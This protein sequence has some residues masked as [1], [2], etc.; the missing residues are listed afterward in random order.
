M[1]IRHLPITIILWAMALQ[2]Q[3]QIPGDS[4]ARELIVAVE[5][6]E[7]KAIKGLL[8][9]GADVNLSVPSRS[10][11]YLFFIGRQVYLDGI[12]KRISAEPVYVSAIHANASRANARTLP[13]LLK[14]GANIDAGDS[15]GKTPLMYA[16]R[17]PGGESYALQLLQQGA[18]YTT[19]DSAGNSAM[20]Y[21]ALGGNLEGIYL[22]KSGG[23][24]INSRNQDGMT[25][26]HVAV[27]RS[28]VLVFDEMLKLGA[29][30]YVRDNA[31][32]NVLHYAA[33]YGSRDLVKR[34]YEMAP[35]LFE[36]DDT[37]ANPLDIAHLADNDEVAIY[38]RRKGRNFGGYRYDELLSAVRAGNDSLLRA[39]LLD[40]ANPNRP[41]KN[42]PIH[43][44]AAAGDL[45]CLDALLD[46]H[47]RLDL[48]D[49]A[50]RSPLRVAIES[51]QPEAAILLL[52][53]GA[54]PESAWLPP[55]VWNLRQSEWKARY[56]PMVR[57]VIDRVEDPDQSGGPLQTPS[58]HLA[59]YLGLPDVAERLLAAGAQVGLR[60]GEGWTPLHWAVIK[61]EVVA[62]APDKVRTAQMLLDKGADPKARSESPKELP[63]TQPYLARRVPGNATALD[64]LDYALPIDSS[65]WRLL[66]QAGGDS[67]LV[68][69]D[70]YENGL[71]LLEM[72]IVEA[73]QVEFNK[74]L[75]REPRLAEAYAQRG[76]CKLAQGM[77][78]GA[79]IDFEAALQYRPYF[80][81]AELGRGKSLREMGRYKDAEQAFGEAIEQGIRTGEA[82]FLRGSARLSQGNREGA[83]ADYAES[84]AKGHPQGKLANQLN[85]G[86]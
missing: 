9:Q 49:S 58:L 39:T 27:I 68:A 64:L 8:K 69:A 6:G 66:S 17:Q 38:F 85:C 11:F 46:H 34:I 78:D 3:A 80:P 40:G 51:A 1:R 48:L 31:R 28:P 75:K 12:T 44:A 29:D 54:Q 2:L 25:P 13:L 86:K 45:A 84:A 36:E 32:M 83:C 57:E 81:E 26:L 62:E 59:A 23:V 43:T 70:F 53:R 20:H 24:N 42:Y 19:R 33:A 41:A 55:M 61:R 35:D 18:N 30:P 82:Y 71:A 15:K 47:A 14:A 22:A 50:G 56:W 76:N 79:L 72:G 67:A 16:L 73:A 37:G 52:Q 74:A 10:P 63:H 60:D 5:Q 77:V 7:A 21:A 4:L 65:M